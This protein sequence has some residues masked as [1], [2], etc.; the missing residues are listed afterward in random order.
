[1]HDSYIFRP[2]DRRKGVG[3]PLDLVQGPTGSVVRSDTA[4][5]H[6]A[7]WRERPVDIVRNVL[8]RFVPICR[9]A[10]RVDAV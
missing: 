4:H 3:S 7:L 8:V 6:L 5:P 1:M 10:A 2:D 9:S